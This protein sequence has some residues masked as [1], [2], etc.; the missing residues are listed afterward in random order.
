MFSDVKTS[1]SGML[2]PLKRVGF[3]DARRFIELRAMVQGAWDGIPRM[4]AGFLH[5]FLRLPFDFGL[6]VQAC[7]CSPTL[8]QK[9]K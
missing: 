3:F 7:W 5:A 8:P 4:D 2:E 9:P 1:A 6:R